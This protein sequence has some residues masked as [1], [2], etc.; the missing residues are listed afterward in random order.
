M[1]ILL[2]PIGLSAQNLKIS[3]YFDTG[4]KPSCKYRVYNN[5]DD[6]NDIVMYE[7]P[8]NTIY[9]DINVKIKLTKW[10]YA[11]HFLIYNFYHETGKSFTPI[12]IKSIV[13]FV[14][15]FKNI[16]L[17]GEHFCLHP[18]INNYQNLPGSYLRGSGD[19]IYIKINI[20]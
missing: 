10:L 14:F 9:T 2:L 4:W 5:L 13:R 15:K 11:E 17:G 8:S 19:K 18:V 20:N 1:I 12:D 7:Y 16:E 6:N 3:G